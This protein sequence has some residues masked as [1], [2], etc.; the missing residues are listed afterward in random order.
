MKNNLFDNSQHH[1]SKVKANSRDPKRSPGKQRTFVLLF[2]LYIT[3]IVI[4]QVPYLAQ[5]SVHTTMDETY[6]YHLKF[7]ADGNQSHYHVQRYDKN[8]LGTVD[9]I[10]TTSTNTLVVEVDNIRVLWINSPSVFEDEGEDVFGKEPSETINFYKFY[11]IERDHFNVNIDSPQK[12][13][14]MK[15]CDAPRPQEVWVNGQKWSEGVDYN[16]TRIGGIALS[17]VR[18]GIT[19]VDIYFKS[20]NEMRPYAKAHA[21]PQVVPLG[22]SINFNGN[23]SYDMDGNIVSYVWD[24]GDGTYAEEI[25]VEHSFP[26]VGSYT[27]ILSVEDDDGLLD[28]DFCNITVVPNEAR[29]RIL[30]SIPDQVGVEDSSPWKIDL[31]DH[32]IDPQRIC[33]NPTWSITGGDPSICI[34]SFEYGRT[35]NDKATDSNLWFIPVP[36][37]WGNQRITLWLSDQGNVLDS[38][39]FWV[40]LTPVNDPPSIINTPSLIIH[41]DADYTFDYTP[42]VFDLDTDKEDLI[43][44]AEDS[45]GGKPIVEDFNVTYNYPKSLLGTSVYATLRVSDG[46][47]TGIEI[48]KINVSDDWVPLV[49]KR[50]PNIEMYEGQTISC[51][52]DL[53]EYF[54]DPDEDALFYSYG[55][56]NIEVTIKDDHCVNITSPPGWSGVD[57]VTFR[58]EDPIGALAEDTILVT[59]WAVNDPPTITNVPDLV[60]HH[61][62]DYSF[63]LKP[64]IFDPDN[65]CEDLVLSSSGGA[66]C[67]FDALLPTMMVLNY[68]ESFSN[69]EVSLTITVSDGEFSDSQTINVKVTNDYPPQL[70]ELIPY[71]TFLEDTTL[72]SE[73][74]LNAYFE[75]SDSDLIFYIEG[76]NMVQ[77]EIDEDGWVDFKAKKD[78]FGAERV[79][80]R[81]IDTSGGI[82]EDSITITVIPVNDAPGFLEIPQQKGF[83]DDVWALDLEDYIYDVDDPKTSLQISVESPEGLV[84]VRGLDLIISPK[85]RGEATF[86]LTVTDGKLENFTTMEISVQGESI[87]GGMMKLSSLYLVLI[88]LAM[89]ILIAVGVFSSRRYHGDFDIDAVLLIDNEGGT[90]IASRVRNKSGNIDEDILGSMFSAVT[91]FIQESFGSLGKERSEGLGMESEPNN[92]D[93]WNLNELGLGEHTIVIE[94]GT[95]VY[96]AIVVTGRP[97]TKLV[98][99]MKRFIKALETL[100]PTRFKNWDGRLDL[101]ED[102]QSLIDK[103]FLGISGGEFDGDLKKKPVTTSATSDKEIQ[104]NYLVPEGKIVSMRKKRYHPL[105]ESSLSTCV[106]SST[107]KDGKD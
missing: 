46:Q 64:Y 96:L 59:V 9:L 92:Y 24:F 19:T 95:H 20:T 85:Q 81:A 44:W 70:L 78:W 66:F 26:S 80:F 57:T 105:N 36:N 79:T 54:D 93:S 62:M 43:M 56:T 75:D 22:W 18:A 28:R 102:V 97:G 16:Y 87:P 29:P 1:Q 25:R 5:Q 47:A 34:L 71:V 6:E 49:K 69:V 30:P 91:E 13:E 76:Q 86:V 35:T 11:F 52:F 84:E 23:E 3:F 12:I 7:P 67:R 63:D 53:D 48:V 10:Y 41:Y 4:S 60:V 106:A 73:L 14:E 68:S 33:P 82:A 21:S 2:S 61:S 90:L 100:S 83:V 17:E 38:Q 89:I 51:V 104:G 103:S 39:S 37:A 101:V 8:A 15:L 50:L 77:V 65:R 98:K 45:I 40:N 27:V 72:E 32:F 58:A 74:N 107:E 31:L 94:R 88:I 42:Y 99:R 55:E